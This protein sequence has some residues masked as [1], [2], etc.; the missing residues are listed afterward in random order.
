MPPLL[1]FLVF[2]C[3]ALCS[4]SCSCLTF[5]YILV[6]CID[7]LLLLL[8]MMLLMHTPRPPPSW[9]EFAMSLL[10]HGAMLFLTFV[11]ISSILD[12]KCE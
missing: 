4:C 2:L 5:P 11:V 1:L 8:L 7:R 9:K 12:D 10:K 6:Y 3:C